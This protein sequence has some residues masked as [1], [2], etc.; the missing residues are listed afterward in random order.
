MA[1]VVSHEPPLPAWTGEGRGERDRVG[2][3]REGQMARMTTATSTRM[4]GKL[5]ADETSRRI[6][7]RGTARGG[8]GRG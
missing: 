4:G 6:S 5:A 7:E 2:M 8:S 1:T 3:R